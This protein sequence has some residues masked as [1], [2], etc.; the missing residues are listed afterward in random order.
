MKFL[1]NRSLQPLLVAVILTS[2]NVVIAEQDERGGK[3]HGPP[4]QAFTVCAEQV[5]GAACSFSGRRG[6]VQGQCAVP[7]REEG[8][9]VCMPQGGPPKHER[10]S[11]D[12]E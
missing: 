6:E 9:L 5:E 3:R 2:S 4:D 10:R 1:D 8:Q 12:E 7:P 11:R